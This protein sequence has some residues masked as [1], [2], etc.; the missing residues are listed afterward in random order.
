MQNAGTWDRL[1]SNTPRPART[2]RSAAPTP[3]Y[4]LWFS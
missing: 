2:D 4:I 1:I 3:I